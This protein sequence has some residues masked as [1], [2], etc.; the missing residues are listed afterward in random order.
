MVYFCADENITFNVGMLELLEASAG[1]A[2]YHKQKLVPNTASISDLWHKCPMI[3]K[4]KTAGYLKLTK[5]DP[6]ELLFPRLKSM[7]HVVYTHI[8]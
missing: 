6:C 1:L 5:V 4:F 7:P 3:Y 2:L 8:L